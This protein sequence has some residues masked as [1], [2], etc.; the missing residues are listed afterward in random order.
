MHFDNGITIILWHC[1]PLS[2]PKLSTFSPPIAGEGDFGGG[3]DSL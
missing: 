1:R 2:T 3:R